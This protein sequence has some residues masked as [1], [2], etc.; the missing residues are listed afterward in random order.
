MPKIPQTTPYKGTPV[1]ND[2]I[3][4]IDSENNDA[5]TEFPFGSNG[6][7]VNVST[8]GAV[9]DGVTDDTDA[10]Q[11][12]LD[13]IDDLVGS[14]TISNRMIL[15]FPNGIYKT[16]YTLL[17]GS[18]IEIDFNGSFMDFYPTQTNGTFMVSKSYDT[19][20]YNLHGETTNCVA[21]NGTIR[22]P[23]SPLKGNGFGICRGK[24]ITVE[25]MK[26]SGLRSHLVDI[27]GGRDIMITG[28]NAK[29]IL[30]TAAYQVDNL[31]YGNSGSIWVELPD[32]SIVEPS[33]ASS[34]DN[35]ESHNIRI[36]NNYADNCYHAVHFHREN[37]NGHNS[38]V[39]VANNIFTECTYP[40]YFDSTKYWKNV[41]INSNIV[42]SASSDTR[43]ILADG[44]I[45]NLVV[46]GNQ[47]YGY[48]QVVLQ[49]V[50]GATLTGFTFSNNNCEATGSVAN[51][52]RALN[53]RY[54]V[55]GAS[56]TGNTFKG[57]QRGYDSS[58]S[59]V[60]TQ[61]NINGN[62]FYYCSERAIGFYGISQSVIS[63][64][65]ISYINDSF[66][67]T[68]GTGTS[69][70]GGTY[71]GLNQTNYKLYPDVT[72]KAGIVISASNT[73]SIVGNTFT[74]IKSAC[75]ALNDNTWSN[76][77]ITNNVCNQ[78]VSF[79]VSDGTVGG[80]L[81]YIKDNIIGSNTSYPLYNGLYLED[82]T[83][84][85]I[86]NNAIFGVLHNAVDLN[87]ASNITL[88]GNHLT[89]AFTT[90]SDHKAFG[91]SNASNIKSYGN[92]IDGS[93]EKY[94]QRLAYTDNPVDTQTCTIGST[95]YTFNDALD[96]AYSILIDA[97]PDVTY[98]NFVAAINKSAGEGT[99][100]GTGTVAHPDVYADIDT[101]N[102]YVFIRGIKDKY[103]SVATTETLGNASWSSSAMIAGNESPFG[104]ASY[105][106][107]VTNN[108]E[109]EVSKYMAW[110][111]VAGS[112]NIR[113]Y[114]NS[115]ND[116]NSA[117]GALN[118]KYA[119][120]SIVTNDNNT[121]GTPTGEP[122]AWVCV[123]EADPST[124]VACGQIGYRTNAGAPTGVTP[125][126]I[127]ERIL[128]TTYNRWFTAWGSG[129]SEFKRSTV[130][131]TSGSGSPVG[132]VTPEE[133]GEEY[134]DTGSNKWYKSYGT[135]NNTYWVALN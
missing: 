82:L 132:S 72:G 97:D 47:F 44:N 128:D 105:Y 38:N 21:K 7:V 10:I 31:E 114:Y 107:S 101:T 77:K 94:W 13:Y 68:D 122:T 74:G 124:W 29:D 64:N 46:N 93:Y 100:Y 4:G 15:F 18:N 75:I 73:W 123:A 92:V 36:I 115:N 120:G 99:I 89:G 83:Y 8:F 16:T 11:E 45:T 130:K 50:S 42:Y 9:G 34:A 95:V 111:T 103:I 59:T 133:V 30:A 104:H 6:G 23:A 84:L 112:A 57:F 86:T 41:T 90:G 58:T 54:N 78:A 12:A 40:F 126:Y 135:G 24:S 51:G 98:A 26:T 127:G 102:G 113:V 37:G 119:V 106:F 33:L 88:I 3:L 43:A 66:D 125:K 110:G 108:F 56:I 27:S 67:L 14:D 69:W 22:T 28:C 39:I 35:Y 62:R 131:S 63:G 109:G 96:G 91:L 71:N 53:L 52:V 80:A 61:I 60:G 17:Y 48:D 32:H 118:H 81:L 1:T 5:I 85:E 25:N 87:G 49:N 70:S 79:L 134:L 129:S 19:D 121:G 20:Y 65:E 117:G 2:R 55:S 76:G 116:P